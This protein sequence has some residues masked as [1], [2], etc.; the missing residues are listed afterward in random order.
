MSSEFVVF[1]KRFSTIP[2][3]FLDDFF[4]I[5]DYSQLFSN[6]KVINFDKV[7]LW[8]NI[9]KYKAIDTLT[10]TYRKNIDYTIKNNKN[11]KYKNKQIFITI[12]TFKKFCQ[13]THSKHGDDVRNYFIEIEKI[14]YRNKNHIIKSYEEKLKQV[15]HNQKPFVNPSKGVIYIFETPN[16]PNHS[17]YKLGKAIDL[18]K[19]LKS[20]KSSLAH[21]IKILFEFEASDINKVETCVKTQLKEFQYKK[22][23]EVYQCNI[24]I[25]KRLIERCDILTIKTKENYNKTINGDNLS[26]NYYMA[27][28]NK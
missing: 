14:L 7:I 21:N 6:E 11:K 22:Y 17:L 13:H 23:K 25:I 8:L 20:H 19:R 12:D 4:S 9:N 3:K 26:N 24:E 5:I 16:S 27:I 15:I 1:L 10:H 18:K 28:Y 2:H